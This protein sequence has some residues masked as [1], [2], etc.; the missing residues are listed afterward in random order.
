[1]S[2]LNSAIE[3]AAAELRAKSD[4][5]AEAAPPVEDTPVDDNLDPENPPDDP[6]DPPR[7]IIKNR[8]I[9]PLMKL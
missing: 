3:S 6:E 4:P 9:S 7:M 5:K 8:M 2:S 1:M